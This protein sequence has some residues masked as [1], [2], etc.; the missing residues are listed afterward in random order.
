M[1]RLLFLAFIIALTVCVLG[2]GAAF[3][4]HQKR[5]LAQNELIRNA[6]EF[7]DGGKYEEAFDLLKNA[8]NAE[9]SERV[10]A[11][12]ARTMSMIPSKKAGS[13]LMWQEL[14][15]KYP[16]SP[17]MPEALLAKA[18]HTEKDLKDTS[19]ARD[20]YLQILEK[21][22]NS[23]SADRALLALA[24]QSI[25]NNNITLAQQDLQALLLRPPSTARDQAE[26]ILGKMNMA[27]LYSQDP[28]PMSTIYMIK[29]GDSLGRLSRQYN[30]PVDLI[31]GINKISPTALRIGQRLKIPKLENLEA[32]LDKKDC[33]LRLY[34]N[35]V[36][37][38]RY[39]LSV[40]PGNRVPLGR[41]TVKNKQASIKENKTA[42]MAT[43]AN[44]ADPLNP[45]GT[46]RINLNKNDVYIH[47]AISPG[48]LGK[49]SENAVIA[50][51]ADDLDELYSLLNN[52]IPIIITDSSKETS[53]ESKK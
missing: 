2:F 18:T 27:A 51:A 49:Q 11:L 46:K 52:G 10:M 31:A 35:K 21:Y 13:L 36:F 17:Y 7:Y 20:L 45:I 3:I 23:E 8:D 34:C 5:L 33:S 24:Q 37:L 14:E 6:T 40:A 15:K 44:A 1:G 43:A 29:Q 16:A 22:P 28:D 32:V 39:R 4:G 42:D 38:Q 48:I 19:K 50:T 9:P 47:Q 25:Q 26:F 53:K 12:R 30:V 41:Y